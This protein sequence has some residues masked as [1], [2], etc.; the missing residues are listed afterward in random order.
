MSHTENI[1]SIENLSFGYRQKKVLDQIGLEVPTGS[2]YGFLGPNGAGKTTTI[3][4]LLGLLRVPDNQ[5][6]LFGK[7]INH[8]R[9]ET[10]KS[11]GTMVEDPSL[12][13]HLSAIDNLRNSCIIRKIERK[14]IAVVLEQVGLTADSHRKIRSYSSGM[15]QRLALA[16]ALLPEP[17]LLMLDEPINGLDPAGI[18]DIRNL[19]IDLN[20]NHGIT[21]FLSSHIL[22]EIEKLCSHVAVVHNKH[23]LYQGSMDG[24]LNNSKSGVRLIVETDQPE[25]AK[26]LLQKAYPVETLGA[27][28]IVVHLS[29][30]SVTPRVASALVEAGIG[31]LLLQ[32]DNHELEASFLE[33]LKSN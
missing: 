3:K 4:I 7:D 24:L 10:L 16:Q 33:L 1:I 21:I 5:V 11:I 9:I 27:H 18:I 29:D 13:D 12:Y 32:P 17:Q 20:V 6:R 22:S 15:K 25:K 19:L 30:R 28:R 8:F 31:I 26:L 2:I 14:R 23:I